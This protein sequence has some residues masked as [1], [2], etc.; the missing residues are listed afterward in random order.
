MLDLLNPAIELGRSFV[1][2][3]YQRSFAPM[4]LLWSGIARFIE[5]SPQYAVLFGAGQHQQQLFVGVPPAHGR[6]SVRPHG[7]DRAW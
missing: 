6:I 5:C 4:R 2:A 1:R 3:E 7:R